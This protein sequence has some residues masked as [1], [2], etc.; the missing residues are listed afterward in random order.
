MILTGV[1]FSRGV[2]L[3]R[4]EYTQ[5]FHPYLSMDLVLLVTLERGGRRNFL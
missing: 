1:P 4:P 5:W 2:Q 3:P